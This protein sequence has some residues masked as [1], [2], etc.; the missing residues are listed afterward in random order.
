VDAFIT[1][2]WTPKDTYRSQYS[3]DHVNLLHAGI[4]RFYP[5]LK[6]FI[7]I[8]DQTTGFAPG[9]E[10]VPLWTEGFGFS[11]PTWKDGPACYPRLYVWSREFA[12]SLGLRRFAVGDIDMVPVADL[13]P[14]FERK[15]PVLI[16]RTGGSRIPI[17]ASLIMM[18]A[19][20]C[21]A[22]WSYFIKDPEWAI[23]AAKRAGFRGSDQAWISYAI[24]TNKPGWERKDGVIQY[25]S[26]IPPRP[27]DHNN[28]QRTRRTVHRHLELPLTAKRVHPRLVEPAN[29]QPHSARA[30]MFPQHLVP[31]RRYGQPGAGPLPKDARLVIFTG[32]PDPWDED[33]LVM[34]PWIKDYLWPSTSSRTSTSPSA[35]SPSSS[36]AAARTLPA[37]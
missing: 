13:T 11:N 2:L 22:V 23:D 28:P 6:R 14:I 19:G 25:A 10:V 7:C 4:R 30:R 20:Y 27:P 37:T 3:A 35:A 5:K 12:Q 36:L 29:L 24:G 9:I 16:W 34:S 15:E 31:G 26:I 21:D 1:F 8:T 32:K 17:C 18:D 33:A